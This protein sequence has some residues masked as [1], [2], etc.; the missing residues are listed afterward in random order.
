MSEQTA[1]RQETIRSVEMP[2]RGPVTIETI[3]GL[4]ADPNL[5]GLADVARKYVGK[6]IRRDVG[7]EET[8]L[9][10]IKRR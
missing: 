3:K 9:F 10:K 7:T 8:R 6:G 5:H 2:K 1:A 4:E